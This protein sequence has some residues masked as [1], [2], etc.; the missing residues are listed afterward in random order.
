M[1]GSLVDGVSSSSPHLIQQE[2]GIE[3]L[4][5]YYKCKVKRISLNEVRAFLC[6]K[7]VRYLLAVFKLFYYYIYK[8]KVRFDS[9]V[10]N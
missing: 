4:C 7:T 10:I 1:S 6:L 9:V 5:S 2:L 3:Q 8:N